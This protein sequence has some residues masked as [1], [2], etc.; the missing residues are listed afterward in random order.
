M[1][2]YFIL[3]RSV[4]SGKFTRKSNIKEVRK[5]DP[6]RKKNVPAPRTVKCNPLPRIDLIQ[7]SI[8]IFITCK[9]FRLNLLKYSQKNLNH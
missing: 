1:T 7:K 3:P 6:K 9:I 5:Q 8:L 2:K 4:R